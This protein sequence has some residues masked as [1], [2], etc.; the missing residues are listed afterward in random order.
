M[1]ANSHENDSVAIDA[2]GCRVHGK[3]SALGVA[4]FLGI[5]FARVIQRFRPAQKVNLESLG[6]SIDATS[7]GPRC[8]QHW[9]HGPSRRAHLYEGVSTSSNHPS[10][11]A[12]C[13]NLNMY[14]PNEGISANSKLPV[15]VWIHGG[16]WVFGDGGQE[17]G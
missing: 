2:A 17:Y 12:D 3:I 5:P 15:L 13:L 6:S 11:E 1:T 7:F 8:P 14:V 10:S 16:G 4:N 9:N